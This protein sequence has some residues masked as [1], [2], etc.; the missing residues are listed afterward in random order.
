MRR[1]LWIGVAL[2]AVLAV[3]GAGKATLARLDGG[4]DT[5]AWLSRTVYPLEH[6]GVIRAAAK[7]NRVDPALV[8]AVIYVESGFD[9]HARSPQG[10][11]GLMQVLP[12][13]ARQ[14]ARETG[15]SAFVT[16][17]LEDPKVNVRYGTYY[18]RRSLDQFRGDTFAAVAAYN[19]GGGAVGRWAAEAEAE[20]HDLRVED[21][22]YAETRAYVD[23]V[24]RVREVYRET[25]GD[26]LSQTQ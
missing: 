25:Y 4:A 13:T 18:L 22:P 9:E 23:D 26:E 12:E 5:P 6:Q 10:A 1:L 20:G 11:V 17:D 24:L 16:D 15:G 21:I 7:K 19:A 8:A 3:V 14:I 2:L